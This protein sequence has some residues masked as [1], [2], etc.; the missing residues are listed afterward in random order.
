MGRERMAVRP[1][2]TR[3][4][5]AGK[6]AGMGADGSAAPPDTARLGGER[7]PGR[8]QMAVLPLRTRPAWA[9]EMAGKGEGRVF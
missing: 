9:G 2:R 1:L 3:P 8:E 5:W 7:R 6:T 4:A